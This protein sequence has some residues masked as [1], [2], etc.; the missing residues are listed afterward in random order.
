MYRFFENRNFDDNLNLKE[1]T[2]HHLKNVVR[3]EEGEVFQVVFNDGIYSLCYENENI[4]LIEKLKEKNESSVKLTLF[5]GL[6]K[7]NKSEDVLRHT[8]EIGVSEFYPVL[9]D[10]SISDISKK[11]E[12]KID[13]YQKIVE[14]AAK[15]SKRDVIP[16]VHN[17]IKTDDILN[18]DGDLVLCYEDEETLNLSEILPK[19]SNKI[20]LI[21]GPEGGI[22]EREIKILKNANKVSLGKRILR[23]ETASIAA[24]FYIIHGKECE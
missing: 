23:A 24:S 11:M 12:K 7:S 5:F 8:T 13:R 16:V 6:L 17:M 19:L 9:M 22:S 2:L 3:I 15:Q 1:E 4:K 20:G 21:I 14:S 10:R 18:F